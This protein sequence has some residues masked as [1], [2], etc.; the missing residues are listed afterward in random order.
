MRLAACVHTC[1]KREEADRTVLT[2]RDINGS[3]LK[4]GAKSVLAAQISANQ[5]S[6]QTAGSA[7][8]DMHLFRC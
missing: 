1:V 8:T 5:S 3:K 6:V 4:T 2:L 7:S